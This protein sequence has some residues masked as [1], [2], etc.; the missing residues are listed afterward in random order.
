MGFEPQ[1]ARLPIVTMNNFAERMKIGIDEAKT[2]LA[3][4]KHKYAMYYN[5]R[6]S[7][8]PEF[9]PGDMVWLNGTDIVTTWP[10]PKLLH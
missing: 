10:S 3:K 4:V 8:A 5:C 9:E 2:A 1:Q 6:R 7:P